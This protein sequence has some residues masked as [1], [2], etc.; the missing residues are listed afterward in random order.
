MDVGEDALG[1]RP[2]ALGSHLLHDLS[3]S[4][5]HIQ[6][7]KVTTQQ[8]EGCQ[9]VAVHIWIP[10]EVVLKS[11]WHVKTKSHMSKVL[12]PYILH[13]ILKL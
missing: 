12:C 1:G 2:R 4:L 10:A 8:Q 6:P 7:A 11:H 9:M 5:P 3:H 13:S